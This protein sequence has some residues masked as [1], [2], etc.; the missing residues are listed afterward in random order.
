MGNLS[1][2]YCVS[3]KYKNKILI[4]FNYFIYIREGMEQSELAQVY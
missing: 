4:Y 2:F 3:I 1:L